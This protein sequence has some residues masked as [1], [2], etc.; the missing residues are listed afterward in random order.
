MADMPAPR[1][2]E[3]VYLAAILDELKVLH[4]LLVQ[5]AQPATAGNTAAP[6]VEKINPP[7]PEETRRVRKGR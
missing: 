4:R 7:M 3:Q 5:E 1:T 2:L 6:T